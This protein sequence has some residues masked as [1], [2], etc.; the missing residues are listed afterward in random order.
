MVQL[1]VAVT[2]NKG[3]YITSLHPS[4]FTIAEDGITQKLA[5][6]GQGDEPTRRVVEDPPNSNHFVIQDSTGQTQEARTGKLG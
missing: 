3:N 2:E 4:D 1:N 5:T 6:F